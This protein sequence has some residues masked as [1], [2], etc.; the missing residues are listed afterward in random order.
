M[1][2]EECI[3]QG[4]NQI[5]EKED[6]YWIIY[7]LATHILQVDKTY[8]LTHPEQVLE[9]KEEKDFQEA[10]QK[11][12]QGIPVQ[13]IT[14]KQEFMDSC[15]YV[16]QDVLIPQPD[17]EILVEEVIQLIKQRKVNILDLCCG[18][19]CIGISLKKF[20]ENANVVLSDVSQKAIEVAKKNAVLLNVDV[21]IIQSN[22]FENIKEK[23]DMI[24]SN[25]PYIETNV[26]STLSQEV[27][28]EPHIALDGGEDGLTFY[29]KIIKEAPNYLN[30]KGYLCL[31]I[32]FN[33]KKAVIQLLQENFENM[34]T[35]QD[36]AGNDRVIIAKMKGE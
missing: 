35:K 15:F 14:N 13:Y 34:I 28:N 33:Q 22:L 3:K 18:S 9:E 8:I 32:G 29:R 36:L 5:K 23:Y 16:N 26:I 31:E 17:T 24:V 30:K 25:P 12:K 2:I 4:I 11:I 10:I 19:G 21:Q 7:L 6:A 1:T 27:Q 20:L